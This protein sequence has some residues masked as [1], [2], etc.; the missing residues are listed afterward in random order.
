MSVRR[1]MSSQSQRASSIQAA[2]IVPAKVAEFLPVKVSA[3]HQQLFTNT[4]ENKKLLKNCL[5]AIMILGQNKQT[6]N[7]QDLNK[8]IYTG[9]RVQHHT[10]KK[11]VI[12]HANH[13]LNKYMGMRLFDLGDKY[14]LVNSISVPNQCRRDFDQEEAK[15]LAAI[16]LALMEIF[17][18]SDESSSEDQIKSVMATIG[19][20]EDDLKKSF[21]MLLKKLYIVPVRDRNV[22]Q[23][24]KLYKWGPRAIAEVD[25]DRFMKSFLD[26]AEGGSA[27]DWPEQKRRI[28]LLKSVPNRSL[29]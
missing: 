27:D 13:D 15:E 14:L 7:K 28:E 22:Q 5:S 3:D 12:A 24:E 11:A 29:P 16:F 20:S 2:P 23:E 21:N 1:S 17:S 6:I 8:L 25:P 9:T 18:S 10:I 26:F 4:E 19:M